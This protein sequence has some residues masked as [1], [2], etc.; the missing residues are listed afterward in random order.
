[1]SCRTSFIAAVAESALSLPSVRDET[2]NLFRM[3]ALVFREAYHGTRDG[4]EA[5]PSA[6]ISRRERS[7]FADRRLLHD[8]EAGAI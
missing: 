7:P 1:M 6:L 3:D 8:D 4:A 5:S 2:M